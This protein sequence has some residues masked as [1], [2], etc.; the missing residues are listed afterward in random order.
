M[1]VDSAVQCCIQAVSNAK[2]YTTISSPEKLKNLK[3]Q[4]SW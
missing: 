4:L 3:N 1:A 2:K